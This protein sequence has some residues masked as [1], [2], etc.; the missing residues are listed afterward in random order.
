MLL[1]AFG[2]ASAD[3]LS[4]AQRLWEN[5]EFYK[6]FQIFTKLAE[7]GNVNAQV[8]LGEMYGFGEG[9]QEDITKAAYWLQQAV[10]KG[11]PEAAE[12]LSLVQE[13]QKHRSDIAYYVN[14]FDGGNAVYAKFNCARPQIPARS[15]T[16]EEVAEVNSGINAWTECYGRYIV[17][18][19][20]VI[21]PEK[22]IRPEILR[23]MNNDEFN[24]ATLLIGKV[25][26]GMAAETDE[27]ARGVEGESIAWKN[28]TED[29]AR[30][31]NQKL[32]LEKI[33]S[34]NEIRVLKM[35]R[36]ALE[37]SMSSAA[38]IKPR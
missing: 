24:R 35:T 5:K 38:I 12:S 14:S 23:L 6:S 19:R 26:A 31:N 7:S 13:R 3:E 10:A 21:T 8:Q 33:N 27:L 2:A 9:T 20:N 32:A 15:T 34:D 4:D 18:F 17:N 22:T 16:N 11:H 36:R 37:D 29:F 28:A 30:K 1:G 25:Y